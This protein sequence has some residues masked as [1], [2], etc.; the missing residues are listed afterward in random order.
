MGM[1]TIKLKDKSFELS[2]PEEKIKASID[3][4][5]NEIN[6]DLKGEVPV[7]LVI[8]N[9]AFMFASDIL[10][11]IDFDCEVS[12]VKLASYKGTE[13]TKS[14]K[15]LIGVNEDLK[16]RTVVILEDIID[17]GITLECML[18]Q[19]SELKPKS[20]KIATLLFKPKAFIK[21]YRIDYVGLEI[22][23]DFI[24]GYG[25]DYDGLGRNLNDIYKIIK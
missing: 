7:F 9:G 1:S 5:A 20:V 16:D 17:S 10:K 14:I 22:P 11:R 8:L 4:V 12:F 24:V 25:L 21:N 15:K 3:R 13:S 2:I 18:E 6:S 19:L 23:N